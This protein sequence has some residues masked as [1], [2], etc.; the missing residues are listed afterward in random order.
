[1]AFSRPTLSEIIERI[2]GDIKTGLSLS[3][4]LRRSFEEVIAKA[5]AGASHTLHGHIDYEKD[6]L[7]PDTADEVTLLRWG[8]IFGVPRKEATFAQLNVEAT[9]TTGGTL[10][11]DTLAQRSDGVQYKLDTEL[12]VPAGGSTIG[13]WVC[14]TEGAEGN[15]NDGEAL[16]L[17][18]PVSGVNSEMIIDSTAVEGEDQETI[19][20]YRER[21]I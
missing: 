21:I 13:T 8:T 19:D 2:K 16:T 20:D 6:N 5:F 15:M 9:G 14:Q 12:V 1:M 17:L 18:S 10:V 3:A 4:I 11:A 7:L